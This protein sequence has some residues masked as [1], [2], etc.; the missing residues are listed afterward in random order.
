MRAARLREAQKILRQS[1]PRCRGRHRG[2]AQG[3]DFICYSGDVWLLRDTLAHGI[4]D[5]K[6][7]LAAG[8]GR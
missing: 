8:R 4:A 6:A 2:L 7:A 1:R 3:Y 5:L